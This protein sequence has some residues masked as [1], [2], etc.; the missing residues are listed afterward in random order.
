MLK[1]LK[2]FR[3]SF[4]VA[5]F[6]VLAANATAET[7]LQRAQNLATCLQGQYPTLCRH[8]WLSVNER[9]Q[10]DQAEHQANLRTCL[11]GNYPTLCDKTRLNAAEAKQVAAAEHQANLRVCLTGNY[12]TLCNHSLLSGEE[13]K[14]VAAAEH[15]ANMRIC[16]TGRYKSL[17]RKEL[18]NTSEREQVNRAE[19]SVEAAR[20]ALPTGVLPPAYA[21]RQSYG[22]DDGHWI[23]SIEGDGK[24][25]TLEDGSVWLVG[26]YDTYDS[27]YWSSTDD[28]VACSDKLINVDEGETV[29]AERVR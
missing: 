26:D 19:A 5:A 11:N 12:P 8:E 3:L 23:S 2:I 24:V 25:I 28:V 22:C 7:A 14:Q 21:S 27:R 20:P 1:L 6:T 10:V 29:E 15:A 18:L 9:G 13:T 4:V 16:S 17:C